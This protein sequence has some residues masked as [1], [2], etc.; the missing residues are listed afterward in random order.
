MKSLLLTLQLCC[1]W[2]MLTFFSALS[3][4]AKFALVELWLARNLEILLAQ[5]GSNL[6]DFTFNYETMGVF[7]L[8]KL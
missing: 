6:S 3:M 7:F 5:E 1:V 8:T 2:T 4:V